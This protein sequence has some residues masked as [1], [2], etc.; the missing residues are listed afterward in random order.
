MKPSFRALLLGL[1]FVGAAALRADEPAG[2]MSVCGRL[3]EH[4]GLSAL[5]VWGTSGD[6][7]FAH[8]CLLAGGNVRPVDDLLLN[9]FAGVRPATAS[10]WR[11]F[12]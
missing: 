2:S 7:G 6:F 1:A 3:S 11:N 4:Q 9:P 12:P 8:A 10:A 5:E